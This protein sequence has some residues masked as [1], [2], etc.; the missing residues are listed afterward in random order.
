MPSA[1]AHADIARHD[2]WAQTRRF[3]R[4]LIL[5]DTLWAPQCRR[6]NLFSVNRITPNSSLTV[7]RNGR[8]EFR[9]FASKLTRFSPNVFVSFFCFGERHR[10]GGMSKRFPGAPSRQAAT[11]DLGR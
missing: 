2:S 5:G 7:D 10:A 8:A 6:V 1:I 9:A 4:H 3:H 11:W